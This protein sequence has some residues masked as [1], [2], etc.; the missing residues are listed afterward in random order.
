MRMTRSASLILFVAGLFAVLAP[1]G[2]ATAGSGQAPATPTAVAT[3]AT[4][5]AR[6]ALGMWLLWPDDQPSAETMRR[7]GAA[8]TR[9]V[10][11][12]AQTESRPGVYDWSSVDGQLRAVVNQGYEVVLAVMGSPSWAAATWCG[13][14]YPQHVAS[15]A[16]FMRAVVARYSAA[17]Y[18]IRYFELGNEPDNADAVGNAWVG[19][20]WGKGPNQAAGAGGERYAALLKAAYPAMKAAN[21]DIVVMTGGLAYDFWGDEGGPFDRGF[22]DDFLTAGGGDAIDA[23]NF[24]FYEAMAPRWGSVAG[25]GQELQSKVKAA[26]G[27]IKPLVI[28]EIGSPSDKPAGSADANPYS[29]DQEARFVIKGLVQSLAAG[30]APVLWFQAVDRPKLSGGYAYG[31][32]WPN[33]QPKPG[34][35]A[36]RTL[37]NELGGAVYQATLDDL[38][39]D[40]EAYR[41]TERNQVKIVVWR[42]ASAARPAPFKVGAA[43][44]VLRYV[45]RFGVAHAVADGGKGDLD[46]AR[47]ASVSLAVGPEP[48]FVGIAAVPPAGTPSTPVP[49]ATQAPTPT[50]TSTP[51]PR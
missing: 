14:L 16:R 37:A 7:A 48:L 43:G 6:N 8:W 51:T 19:G 44:G 21:P 34:F 12:W 42:N 4:P 31:L 11:P 10:A 39:A 24:H 28:T 41:F 3:P 36:F 20:C 45:N 18:H 38:G 17:P 33:L 25:K 1:S 22:L 32:L 23:I 47:N 27:K 13:P 26:T 35:V 29:E 9:V 15:Y 50:Q 40:V 30:V 5:P 46:G 49:A 2:A